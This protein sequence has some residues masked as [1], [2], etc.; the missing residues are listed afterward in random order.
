[1]IWVIVDRLTKY[2]HCI[3]IAHPYSATDI[4]KLF[5]EHV[6]KLH[7]ILEEIVSNKD[8][9]FTSKMWQELFSMLGVALNTSIAYH[10]QSDGQTKVVNRCL[11]THLRCFFSDSQADWFSYL[12][13]ADWWHNTIFHTSI[14]TT[15]YEALY[16]QP[17]PL[18]LPYAT[19]DSGVE[20]VDRSLL[21]REF[22]FQ[23]LQYHL[24]RALRRMITQ[25][26]KHRSDVQYKE[27]DWVYLKIQPY[28]Q[29]TL[30][31]SPFCKLSGK[32]YGPHQI[33]QK[34]GKVAYRLS[35]PAQLMLHPTFH[36]SQ[37]KMCHKVPNNINHPRVADIA[38]PFYPQP[39]KIMD[40]RMIQK[41]SKA[42]AQVLIQWDQ[43]LANQATWED[44]HI[45]KIRFPS[46]L[47]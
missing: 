41:G 31:G 47:S 25:A 23:L 6:Y 37:L 14:Q 32:Y 30:S 4:A 38:S 46:F 21:T 12:A 28:R 42:V 33:L 13:T 9:I 45:L 3:G 24:Q 15:P 35:L 7:D 44:Y 2:T 43:L 27:G 40:R 22:K 26:N 5:M 19:G 11:E 29:V 8:P 39:L 16:G 1:M 36:V 34:I 20:E 17:P 10:P 18:H